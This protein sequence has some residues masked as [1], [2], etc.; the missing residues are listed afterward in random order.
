MLDWFQD[1]SLKANPSKFQLVVFDHEK[2][3]R[4]FIVNGV[5]I[6]STP[7]VKLLGIQ[8]DNSLLFSKHV[9]D[10]CLKAGRKIN[11]LS[12]LSCNLTTEA[13]LLMMQTFILCHF[14]YC[15]VIWHYCSKQDLTKI[16]KIQFKALK[17]VYND[18]ISSYTDLRKKALRPLMYIERQKNI[19]YEVY[20]SVHR[21]SPSYLHDMFT[22]LTTPY[23]L[24]KDVILVKPKYNYIKHV[25]YSIMY[26]GV[27]LWNSLGNVITN[28]TNLIEF[29]N[30]LQNWEGIPCL[31]SNCI[32]CSLKTI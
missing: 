26:E 20:K 11:A 22:I 7:T 4:T 32:H 8:I 16:E 1:N 29:K 10:L 9:S 27:T 31:C 14:N 3:D 18:F 30:L 5:T 23:N 13:K 25:K 15:S 12:R 6:H 17:F 19:L 24:R 2:D 28:A 21:I